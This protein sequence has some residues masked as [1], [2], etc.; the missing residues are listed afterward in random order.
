MPPGPPPDASA[1][2]PLALLLLGAA[3]GLGL[4][5]W[6]LLSA[7]P[8]E[9]LPPRAVAAVN[10]TPVYADEL[11]RLVAGI[12]ADTE[13]PA[14]PAMQRHALDRLIDE[15]LLVQ[16]GLELGLATSDRRVRAD[17][18]AAM[19]RSV[20]VE[21]E[22][23]EPSDETLRRFYAEHG[24]FFTPPGRLHVRQ[25]F[26]G[27]GAAD[28]ADARARAEEAARRLRAGEPLAEVRDALGDPPVSPLPDVP[29]PPAKLREYAGP[30]VL[31][32]ARGLAPGEVS[33]PV[34]SG[35]GLHVLVVVSAEPAET[36]PFEQVEAQVRAEW[37]RRQG[38]EALRRYLDELR[39]RATLR[40]APDAPDAPGAPQDGPDAP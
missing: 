2:R 20:V 10:G 31:E 28:G 27:R 30:T 14:E 24:G 32:A 4:A 39:E 21:A 29:L 11:A 5:A 17:L 26:V 35:A 1:R 22:D 33:D 40:Y 6:G 37:R 8:G 9:E 25:V 18:V 16:R 23:R 13:A 34:R 3:C 15:E 38:E 12:E 7:A 36:P 19:I